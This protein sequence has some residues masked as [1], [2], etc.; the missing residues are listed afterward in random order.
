MGMRS[1]FF[2]RKNSS[3]EKCGAAKMRSENLTTKR[4][5][6]KMTKCDGQ[7]AENEK[8]PLVFL[9]NMLIESFGRFLYT[10]NTPKKVFSLR[11][12]KTAVFLCVP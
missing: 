8:L 3:K 7:Y 4:F 9:C 6:I 2:K 11:G 12:E 5:P 1:S 10:E